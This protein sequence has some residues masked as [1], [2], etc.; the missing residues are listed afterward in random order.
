MPT[1]AELSCASDLVGPEAVI[2]ID[3]P[4]GSGK[5]TTARALARRLGLTYIDTGAMY[6]ALTLAALGQGI[7]PDDAAALIDLLA[8]ASL[9][10]EPADPDTRVFWNGRDVSR[11]IRTPEIDAAVS[12]VAAHGPVRQRMVERQRELARRGGAVMEGRDI[13]SVV[14]PLA[15]TKIYLDAT[16]EAR[17]ERRWR[18]AR[19]RGQQLDRGEVQRDLAARD[20]QDQ[21]RTEGPLVISPDAHVLDTSAWS[22]ARQLDEVDL[23]CRIN[24]WLDRR[25]DWDA[26]RAWLAMPAKYRLVFHVFGLFRRLVGQREIGR[27][28]ATVPPGSIVAS[29]HISWFD[30]PLVGGALGR[31]PIRTLAKA[32]LFGSPFTRALFHWMDAIPINRRGYDAEAFEAAREALARGDNLF[33]FPEGTRRAPGRLGPIKGGIGILAQETGAPILPIYV[34]GTCSLQFGGNPLSPHEI[35]FGPLVRLHGLAALKAQLDP[36]SVTA[37]IGSMTLAVLEELQARSHAERPF[38]AYERAV[39][40]RIRRKIRR[41]RPFEAA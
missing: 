8:G 35:R 36:K 34:R 38:T 39:Q 40:L 6:R 17:A 19:E 30:P 1:R 29:N 37:R 12:R 41:K 21:A 16:V 10:L 7:A 23:A 18:Q 33:L 2:A 3:G 27:P 15:T 32:E 14:L 9:K 25:I 5:S 24:P 4:A 22:L 13:G 20:A 26:R 11:A 28:S 31:S